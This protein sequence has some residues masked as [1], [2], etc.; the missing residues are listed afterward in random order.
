MQFRDQ[1]NDSKDEAVAKLN[2][3]STEVLEQMTSGMY[4]A[5]SSRIQLQLKQAENETLQ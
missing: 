5:S 4:E 2:K 1:L 3:Q